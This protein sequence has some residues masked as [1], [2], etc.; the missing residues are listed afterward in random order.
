MVTDEQLTF[1]VN[2]FGICVFIFIFLFHF[3]TVQTNGS[4]KK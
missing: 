3:V 4:G 2:A 1:I